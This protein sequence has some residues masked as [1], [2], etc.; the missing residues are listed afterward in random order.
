MDKLVNSWERLEDLGA[1]GLK[2]IQNPEYFCF[3]I[4]AVLLAWFASQAVRR[5]SK[6]ID[7][8]TGTG[9]IPLLLWAKTEVQAIDALEIQP[10]MVEMARR[11]VAINGLEEKIRIY[12]MDLRSPDPAVI[13]ANYDIITSNPPYMKA[14]QGFRHSAQTQAIARH[15]LL[16]SIGDVALFA[17]RHL[18]DRGKIFLVHRADRIADIICALRE[19][20]VEVKRIQFV[21]P[22]SRKP[23]NLVLVEGMKRGQ[24][25]LRA[26]KPLVVYNEDGSY[27][28]DINAIYGTEGPRDSHVLRD[29]SSLS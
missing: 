14:A 19:E 15:E 10:N 7:L 21:H 18:K 17:K 23:A 25:G 12:E 11:S 13:G 3:G 8:G 27:T 1:G 20:G 6:V 2:I 5:R 22:Y 4:D 9:I 24:P 26:E 16:C 28:A 29:V